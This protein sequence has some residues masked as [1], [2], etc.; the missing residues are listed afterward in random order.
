[1]RI[2]TDNKAKYEKN[3]KVWTRAEVNDP[4]IEFGDKG[5]Y[6]YVKSS[7]RNNMATNVAGP[8]NAE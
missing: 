1:M 6:L 2:K 7:T 5:P 3:V 4:K 8:K